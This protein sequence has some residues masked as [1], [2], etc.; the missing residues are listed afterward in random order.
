MSGDFPLF[1]VSL[2][3]EGL[4][5]AHAGN[6][7]LP[8]PPFLARQRSSCGEIGEEVPGV[9]A[10]YWANPNRP[11]AIQEARA[12]LEHPRFRGIK[13][14]PLLDSYHPTTRRCTR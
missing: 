5:R 6:G 14:H 10:L 2:D 3:Q 8:G 1:N 12:F 9:W 7:D 13:F 11:G 4:A